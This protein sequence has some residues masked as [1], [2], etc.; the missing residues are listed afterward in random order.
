MNEIYFQSK[1]AGTQTVINVDTQTRECQFHLEEH[2][3]CCLFP[4]VLYSQHDTLTVIRPK[5]IGNVQSKPELLLWYIPQT[6]CICLYRNC[7]DQSTQYCTADHSVATRNLCLCFRH[8]IL[9][10]RQFVPPSA[11]GINHKQQLVLM[12][13][14]LCIQ[15]I[16]SCQS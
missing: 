16:S 15:T 10:L 13:C 6:V 8:E 2:N 4:H 9:L 3:Q 11:Y 5:I 1:I 14:I 7:S 12:H